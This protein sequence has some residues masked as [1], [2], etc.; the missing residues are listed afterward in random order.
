MRGA[1][2]PMP[3]FSILS[4]S[5]ELR[6]RV[7]WDTR[8]TINTRLYSDMLASGAKAV[9]VAML[10]DHPSHGA[11]IMLPT[12]SRMDTNTYIDSR[13]LYF[14]NAPGLPDATGLHARA[15]LPAQGIDR[16]P[17]TSSLDGGVIREV[18]R[19]VIEDNRFSK[20]DTGARMVQRVF[21]SKATTTGTS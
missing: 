2:A 4:R 18:R 7:E 17:F 5:Q 14:P 21:Q 11:R 13:N 10:K 19:S 12:T 3:D 15:M 9:T 16:N 8:D 6:M 20:D 1:T